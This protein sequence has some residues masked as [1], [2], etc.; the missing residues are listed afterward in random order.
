M[1]GNVPLL[2][3]NQTQSFPVQWARAAEHSPYMVMVFAW[4]EPWPYGS[5]LIEIPL[6]GYFWEKGLAP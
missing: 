2:I 6:Y 4:R 1:R 3:L 5:G